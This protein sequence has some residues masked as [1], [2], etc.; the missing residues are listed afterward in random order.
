MDY[1]LSTVLVEF[2][3]KK[4]IMRAMS[5]R[6]VCDHCGKKF[7]L[8]TPEAKECPF[9]FWASSVK[10]EDGLAAEKKNPSPFHKAAAGAERKAASGNF[11]KNLMYLF[12][13]LLFLALFAAVGFFAYKGYQIF[14]SSS[15]G[16]KAFSIKPQSD[17]KQSGDAAVGPGIAALSAQE[18]EAL[19]REV[20]VPADRAPDPG[21][22]EI[23]GRLVPFQTGTTEKLPSAAWTLE[24]YQKMIADQEAFYKMPFS[25]SYRKKLEELFKTKYL[26]ATDAFA[27]GDV[28]AARNFWVESLAFPLYSTDLKKHRAVALTMLRPFINDTLSKVSAMNQSVVDRAKRVQEEALSGEYQKM[29][30]LIAQKKWTEALTAIGAMTAEVDQL[31]KNAK[32]QVAPPPYPEAFGTIDVDLQRP[33]MDLMTP[34]P[35]STADLQPLQQDLVEKKQVIETFTENYRMNAEAIYRSALELIRAEKW[36]EAAQTLGSIQGPPALQ[37][38]AAVKIAILGKMIKSST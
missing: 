24:Q 8:E 12:R 3:S 7:E 16:A 15:R 10:R 14:V 23:L 32:P 25:R 29:S 6:F 30:G 18:K 34:S 9:C 33:L 19:S 5:Y 20:K 1:V 38:D 21:E 28:L 22:Q 35:S 31:R 27:K 4:V 37:E 26:A 13:A 2:S 17:I 11:L 36:Q